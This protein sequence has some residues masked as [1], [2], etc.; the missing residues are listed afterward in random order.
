MDEFV[1]AARKISIS[2]TNQWIDLKLE[3]LVCRVN[4][5]KDQCANG[6]AGVWIMVIGDGR[7][8]VDYG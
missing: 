3:L 5:S 4:R 6:V 1:T 2:A 7:R 8:G